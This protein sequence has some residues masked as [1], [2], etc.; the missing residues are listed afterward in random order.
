MTSGTLAAFTFIREAQRQ[1]N[2]SG[3]QQRG[4]VGESK[5]NPSPNAGSKKDALSLRRAADCLRF[6]EGSVPFSIHFPIKAFPKIAAASSSVFRFFVSSFPSFR[7]R[8]C[9]LAIRAARLVLEADFPFRAVGEKNTS[10]E[11]R[12]VEKNEGALREQ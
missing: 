8:V 4:A 9:R 10:V 11:F 7:C 2:Y 5:R 6:A 3:F 1:R 12:K